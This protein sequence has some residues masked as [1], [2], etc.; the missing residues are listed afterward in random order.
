MEV[1]FHF[2]FELIKISILASVYSIIILLAFRLVGSL[3]INNWFDRVSKR[4]ILFFLITGASIWIVLFVFM[5]TY[6]GDHGLGDSSKIPVGHY[7]VINCGSL[8]PY[9]TVDNNEQIH[10]KT[11]TYDSEKL[12][13]SS[14]VKSDG[15]EYAFLVYD[16]VKDEVQFYNT[17]EEYLIAAKILG[18]PEPDKFENFRRHYHKYWNWWKFCLL[19]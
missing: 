1:L 16:F 13:A 10:F 11:F 15:T 17:N 5:F 9:V 19:P 14:P 8:I 4:K 3:K 7:K 12:Y 6:W 2:V 18:Y